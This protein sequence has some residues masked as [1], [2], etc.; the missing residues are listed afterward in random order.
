MGAQTAREQR[1]SEDSR[2]VK[3]ETQMSHVEFDITEVKGNVTWL[4]REFG[5]FRTEVAARFGSVDISI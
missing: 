5:S 1:M 4:V 2:T 3:L